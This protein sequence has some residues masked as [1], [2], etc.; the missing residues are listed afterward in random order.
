M[1][2]ATA[3]A[4]VLTLLATAARA[5]DPGE[6]R[7]DP[8]LRAAL[9]HVRKSVVLV[10]V[11]AGKKAEVRQG[12]GVLVAVSNEGGQTYGCFAT[13]YHVLDGANSVTLL[14]VPDRDKEFVAKSGVTP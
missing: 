14:R 7:V 12:T 3:T 13:C 11:T 8:T 2:R 1:M 10:K 6:W 5:D 4:A 9:P